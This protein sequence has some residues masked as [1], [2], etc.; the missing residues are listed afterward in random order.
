MLSANLRGTLERAQRRA[1]ERRHELTTT[2]H[3]LLALTEDADA[4]G[5]MTACNVDLQLLQAE[6]AEF[7]DQGVVS[8]ADAAPAGEAGF[9][10]AFRRVIER[11]ALQAR[12]GE[13]LQISGAHIL[14]ALMAEEESHAVY[15]L[16]K[17]DFT[18]LDA[19]NHLAHGTGKHDGDLADGSEVGGETIVRRRREHNNAEALRGLKV[20]NEFCVDL[21]A[22]ARNGH[23]DPLI[24]R[25]SELKRMSQILCRRNKNNPLLVG[26]PGV[27]KT[28]L[29]EGLAQRVVD[30]RAPEALSHAQ[31]WALDMGALIAGTRYRGDFEERIKSVLDALVRLPFPVLFI[32]EIH[33]VVHAGATAG[34]TMDA[35]NLLKPALR[36]GR[37]RCIGSTTYRE[38]RAHLEKDRAFL[39]RFEKIDV[40]EPDQ[41]VAVKI[42]S[43]LRDR[44]EKHHRVR[45]TREALRGAVSLSARF[46]H[47]RRLP[48]KAVDVIDEAG[49]A[50]KAR[51][52]GRARKV[53]GIREIEETIAQIARIPTRN[54]SQDDRQALQT[55]EEDL[56]RLVF[57]Q[58][59]AISNLSGAVRLSRAGLRAGDRPVGS[60]LF[61][62]PT[63]V[64]K[65]ETA[66]QLAAT[67]GV[68][69]HRFDMS[70]YMERH[71]VSRLI[72]APPGYVGFDQ[73]GL[74]TDTVDKDPYCVLLLDEIEKAHPDIFNLLLQVMDYG[75]LTDHNG[76]T[77]DF[78]NV[79]LILTTNAGAV[80]QAREAV[81]FAR[82]RREG[83]DEAAVRELFPP[84]FRNR[85]DATVYFKPLSPETMLRIVDKFV[86]ELEQRLGERNVRIRLGG[87][88]R[89]WL[90]ERGFD[91][92]YGARPLSRLM[93]EQ[94]SKPLADALLFGELATKHGGR[95]H[96]SLR[97]DGE[98][99]SLEYEPA[100]KPAPVADN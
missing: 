97:G 45:Y 25:E 63:G 28:A 39:R 8:L 98:G 9:T 83:E 36:E 94:I 4:A 2:E 76:G 14:V 38:Y 34:G 33:T 13:H 23:I 68:P 74:L 81:G 20:L 73:G 24:G 65:T 51:L 11:A 70:E 79:V 90:A 95:V 69:L 93:E 32:D 58:D 86:L 31:V 35:S 41:D 67:L 75:K 91:S 82:G 3:L 55:L 96:V 59:E 88:A 92:A 27:G 21:N 60:Y 1:G 48:D 10:I 26:D 64:G 56:K 12:G 100:K 54:V 16:E 87:G 22:R 19:V 80:E 6:L 29:V 99:L 18:R 57:G 44:Y 85:L 71:S 49:A 17:Q 52:T 5:I 40:A 15:L 66:R 89:A 61:S 50:Q 72:G 53:I 43:G 47:D 84:E 62:G 46:L 7:L 78:R 37:L 77:V 30:G 42:L